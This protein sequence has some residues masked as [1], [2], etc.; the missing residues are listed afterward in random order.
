MLRIP[1]VHK[2]DSVVHIHIFLFRERI[3]NDSP[4]LKL[5]LNLPCA[6]CSLL[7]GFLSLLCAGFSCSAS[8]VAHFGL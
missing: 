4:L 2:T 8:L 3:V 1:V 6:A 7:W 5:C